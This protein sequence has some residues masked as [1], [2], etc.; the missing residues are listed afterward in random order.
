MTVTLTG[1]WQAITPNSTDGIQTAIIQN[2]SGNAA[3]YT[4][5]RLIADG[6][7]ETAAEDC[8]GAEIVAGASLSLGVSSTLWIKGTAAETVSI[9]FFR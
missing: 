8:P 6:V 5:Q 1:S 4:T 3:L 7:D 9:T 2:P